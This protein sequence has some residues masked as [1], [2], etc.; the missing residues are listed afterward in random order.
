MDQ[1][2]EEI[3]RLIFEFDPTKREA[4]A[5]IVHQIKFTIVIKQMVRRANHYTNYYGNMWYKKYLGYL[6]GYYYQDHPFSYCQ[7]KAWGIFLREKLI[8]SPC[9]RPK[10]RLIERN[11]W[12]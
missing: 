2:P 4:L 10:L 7:E 8:S 3:R 5:K 1:F 6:N 9:T 12:F 11:L